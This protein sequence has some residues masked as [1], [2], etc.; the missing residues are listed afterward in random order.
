MEAHRRLWGL[1]IWQIVYVPSKKLLC[2]EHQDM[3]DYHFELNDVD[4]D[5]VVFTDGGGALFWR[6]DVAVASEHVGTTV[7]YPPCVHQFLST[8]DNG[9][10]G[11]AKH[12]WREKY[13]LDHTDDVAS[14]LFFL[15]CLSSVPERHIR[16]SF[17]CNM[18]LHSRE[19]DIDV[20]KDI[21]TK[22]N[23]GKIRDNL[24]YQDSLQIYLSERS[25][26]SHPLQ[27]DPTS[28]SP[29]LASALDGVQWQ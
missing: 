21:V 3:V 2:R 18:F 29:R 7:Q 1:E 24:Y 4:P 19:V 8:N 25:H 17:H 26:L 20:V 6:K 15:H 9:L 12:Q 23:Y 16:D 13:G 28:P 27:V 22:G 5:T 11:Y 14:S 10:H